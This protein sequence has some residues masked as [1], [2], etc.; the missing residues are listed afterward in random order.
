MKKLLLILALIPLFAMAQQPYKVY[1]IMNNKLLLSL[2]YKARV[3][4]GLSYKG[5]AYNFN[6]IVDEKGEDIKF[7]TEVD[8]IN[9][10]SKRGWTLEQVYVAMSRNE[11]SERQHYLF[12]K[13]VTDDSQI[14]EGIL[15]I[16]DFLEDNKK[17]EQ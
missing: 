16:R 17:A 7:N 2:K 12:S 14:R 11:S 5:D 9:Y 4:F 10:I 1:C 6:T 8:I 15:L 13:T 3:D